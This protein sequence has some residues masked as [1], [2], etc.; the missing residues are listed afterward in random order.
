MGF[1]P[2]ACDATGQGADLSA[3]SVKANK[4]LNKLHGENQLPFFFRDRKDYSVS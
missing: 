4:N 2:S 1:A 3:F